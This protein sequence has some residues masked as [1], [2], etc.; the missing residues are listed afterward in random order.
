MY[1]CDNH[2]ALLKNIFI[3]LPH[4]K[5]NNPYPKMNA[6]KKYFNFP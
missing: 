5:N 2:G 4:L 3:Q 1:R 6:M